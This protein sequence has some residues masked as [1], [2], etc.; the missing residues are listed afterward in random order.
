VV[1]LKMFFL[2]MTTDT[3]ETPESTYEDRTLCRLIPYVFQPDTCRMQG[4]V[5][6]A[7]LFRTLGFCLRVHEAVFA[8]RGHLNLPFS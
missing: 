7:C 5:A 1:D 3:E 2:R 6:T 8:Y 4:V